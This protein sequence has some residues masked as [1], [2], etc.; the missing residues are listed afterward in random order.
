MD[1]S[2]KPT[3]NRL[4]RWPGSQLCLFLAGSSSGARLKHLCVFTQ[5]CPTISYMEVSL[6]HL[7]HSVI[8]DLAGLGLSEGDPV[9]QF[10]LVTLSTKGI[11]FQPPSWQHKRFSHFSSCI[12]L[13]HFFFSV[14][15]EF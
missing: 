8:R 4:T 6:S 1:A 12:V 15:T 2:A 10:L 5:S 7:L 11:I 13:V 14:Q 9:S 3:W